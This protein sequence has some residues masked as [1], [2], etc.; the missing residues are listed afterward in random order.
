MRTS[1]FIAWLAT[2]ALL[3]QFSGL[4]RHAHEMEAHGHAETAPACGHGESDH[5]P[6]EPSPQDEN[7]ECGL[8]DA[9]ATATAATFAAS[10]LIGLSPQQIPLRPTCD[11]IVGIDIQFAH[12]PRGPPA[13]AS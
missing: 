1:A 6:S 12:A 8:C 11:H 9:L 2:A 5:A 4:L 10:V 3:A 13:L 7:D